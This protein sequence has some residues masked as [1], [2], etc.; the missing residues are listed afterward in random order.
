LSG[1]AEADK[2]TIKQ[3]GLAGR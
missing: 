1:S 3:F 2:K